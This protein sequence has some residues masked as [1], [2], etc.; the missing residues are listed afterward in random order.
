MT[1][2]ILPKLK[3]GHNVQTIPEAGKWYLRTRD[4]LD[5]LSSGL[6]VDK[7]ETEISS[8]PD[9]WARPML[10]Q[11]A[12]YN[13]EHV[14]HERV[15][16]EW[17][18]LLAMLALKEVVGLNRLTASLVT[19]PEPPAPSRDGERPAETEVEQRDF[20]RTLS[21][22]LPKSSL[23]DDTS[24]RTLYVFLFNGEPIGMTSPTTL[25]AT[26]ADYLNRISGQDVSWYNGTH[27][28]DPVRILPPRQREI[29][30]GWLD[31]LINQIGRH[32]GLNVPMWDKLSGLLRGFANE[33]GGGTCTLSQS[34]FDIKGQE[35]GVFKYLDKPADGN[36]PDASHVRLIPSEGRTPAKSLLVFERGIAEQWDMLPQD[37]TVEGAQT[38]AAARTPTSKAADVWREADF[39][40][41]KLFVIDQTNAFPA[42]LG[43]GH[44]SLTLPGG[45]TVVTPVLPLNEELMQHL[46]VE[47]LAQR[48]RW[49]QTPGGVKLRLFLR[50]S[51]PDP[52]SEGRTV[53]LSHLYRRE[54][55]QTLAN[56]PTLEIWPDF[57]AAGWKAYYT[58]YSTDNVNETFTAKPYTPGAAVESEVPRGGLA[59]RRYWRTE[60]FPEAMVCRASIP[61]TQTNRLEQQDAGLLLLPA[62]EVQRRGLTYKVGIDFGATSTTICARTGAQ[63]SLV[64]FKNRNVSVT[65]SGDAAQAQ[66]FDFFLPRLATE[67]P[68][69]S[70]FDDFHN[71]TNDQELQPFLNGHAYLL[72]TA[73]LF[74]PVKKPLA[75]DLKWSSETDDRRRVSAFLTQLCLQA[76][77][78]LTEAGATGVRWAFS[79]PTAFSKKQMEGFP[80]IWAQVTAACA[81]LSG[82]KQLDPNTRQTESVSAAL[83]FVNELNAAT[84]M[85]TT[86][87]DIGGSTSD[88]SVWQG[89]KPV[90]QTSVLLAGRALFSDYLWHKPDFLGLFGIDTSRLKEVKS[91][92]PKDR[93]PYYALTDALLRYN[94]ERI[95][96][97]LPVHAGTSQVEALRQHL[98]LGVSGLFY[99]VGLLLRYLTEQEVYRP[100]VP[101]VYVCGNGSRIFNWLDID[102]E[103]QV[104]ALYKAVFSQAAGWASEQAFNVILS[105]KPKTEA[106]YGLTYDSNL[107]GGNLG[108]KVL[109]G[110]S[111]VAEE[112]IE[113]WP[114]ITSPEDGRKTGPHQFSWN[115]TLKPEAFTLSLRP[116]KKLERLTDFID[117]FNKFA[118]NTGLVSS[119]SQ[120][121][122]QMEEVKRRLGQSLSRYRG[123]KETANIVVEP[124]FIMALRHW[125][126]VRLGG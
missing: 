63:P 22:L 117:T 26:A 58:C 92:S 82:L 56:V 87:I 125:L 38:L 98:A 31:T 45:S 14:L 95:S 33:L 80:K 113:G 2:H 89:G 10:F 23:S 71:N 85:G 100:E 39:F 12:L 4:S 9:M 18:G 74:D 51:G 53:E 78:E 124:V 61:N 46:T 101:N 115:I 1:H 70:F 7:I 62:R 83:Y 119:I 27:L 116:P 25:V 104:N 20:L 108:Q 123:V 21:K 114:E 30:S 111:F 3:P 28:R 90:W 64:N 41:K 13:S 72:E 96:N 77:A 49:D 102:G 47:D 52:N 107:Q 75:Y 110:E 109:A 88:V 106:A 81:T 66:L 54:D 105:P 55:I 15:L 67:M 97:Q 121:N 32:R 69:L 42:A 57:R 94:S 120:S 50:L 43:V 91:Q 122:E 36:I 29:L 8:I 79:Y 65:G 19:L 44:Q 118:R 34:G 40:T 60:T 48:V 126:E 68:V 5:K 24:W 86:F 93:R 16:G 35:A 99:Y 11:M 84:E 76:A 59:Q 103:G 37:V 112:V 17:R 6:K 73:E